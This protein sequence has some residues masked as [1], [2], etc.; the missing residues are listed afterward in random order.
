MWQ[1]P[2]GIG[3]CPAGTHGYDAADDDCNPTNDNDGHGTKVAAVLGA[4]GDNGTGGAGLA[5]NTRIMA[6]RISD[7]PILNTPSVAAAVEAVDWAIE[8]RKAGVNVRVLNMSFGGTTAWSALRNA[9]RRAADHGILTV[10]ASG[11]NGRDI[12]SGDSHYPCAYDLPTLI[13]TGG[14]GQNDQYGF[15][16]GAESVDLAAPAAN[17]YGAGST[18]TGTSVAAPLVSAAAALIWSEYPGLTPAQV[19]AK[20]FN[21]VDVIPSHSGKTVTGGRL[22]V[23]KALTGPIGSP[24]PPP[25]STTTTT[26]PPSGGNGGNGGGGSGGEPGEPGG[27]GSGGNSTPSGATPDNEPSG[28]LPTPGNIGTSGDAGTGSPSLGLIGRIAAGSDD[29]RAPPGT[30]DAT[31]GAGKISD[32]QELAEGSDRSVSVTEEDTGGYG[33]WGV[34]AVLGGV[35]LPAVGFAGWRLRR[36]RM[37]ISSA[38]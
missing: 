26:A 36:R 31:N 7:V 4:R 20:I 18:A 38:S 32:G 22:N 23:Y 12:D 9:I 35:G 2:G 27:G 17:V 28:G 5:W 10:S 25:G 19:K 3:G 11:N 30:D 6:L 8:V 29:Q 13:C 14:S 1:N 21:N 15:N 37:L 24:P 34:V 33:A 16:W